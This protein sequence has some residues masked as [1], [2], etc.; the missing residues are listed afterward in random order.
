MNIYIFNVK[1]IILLLIRLQK[2]F[3]EKYT[4]L[5]IAMKQKLLILKHQRMISQNILGQI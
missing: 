5:K 4:M 1:L 2:S 3:L